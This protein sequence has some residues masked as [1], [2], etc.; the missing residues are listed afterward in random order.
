MPSHLKVINF[1]S[2]SITGLKKTIDNVSLKKKKKTANCMLSMVLKTGT[3]REPE[4]E[5]VP[6]LVVQPGSDRWSNR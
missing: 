4:R 5:V 3:G 1:N 2:P 6:V